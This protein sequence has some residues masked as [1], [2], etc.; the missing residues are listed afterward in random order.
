MHSTQ[1]HS[2]T[3]RSG[4]EGTE[5]GEGGEVGGVR[6]YRV[7]VRFRRRASER[8]R[9]NHEMYSMRRGRGAGYC[10]WQ[11]RTG[12]WTDGGKEKVESKKAVSSNCFSLRKRRENSPTFPP[13]VR[14]GSVRPP[15]VV[16]KCALSK[17]ERLFPPPTAGA[18]PPGRM[19]ENLD[20]CGPLPSIAEEVVR[21]SPSPCSSSLSHQ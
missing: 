15:S 19:F 7:R 3:D 11:R 13:P 1:V 9:C 20:E 4:Q 16:R 2:P 10:E 14:R 6:A 21:L 8:G 12:G 18:L 17:L 5:E